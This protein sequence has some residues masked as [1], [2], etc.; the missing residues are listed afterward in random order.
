MS[1]T[2]MVEREA[3]VGALVGGAGVAGCPSARSVDRHK[4]I[5]T[6]IAS[7]N[8]AMTISGVLDFGIITRV[9]T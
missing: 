9:T 8:S 5:E 6:P 1:K 3:L 2:E 4:G 7:M